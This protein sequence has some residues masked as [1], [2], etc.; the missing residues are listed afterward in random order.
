MLVG[1][2]TC[3]V[4]DYMWVEFHYSR[5]IFNYVPSYNDV[6]RPILTNFVII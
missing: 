1:V 6:S 5:V 4:L 3:L 2:H